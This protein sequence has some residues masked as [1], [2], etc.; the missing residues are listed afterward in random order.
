M[1]GPKKGKKRETIEALG[2]PC[3]SEM[4]KKRERDL[5]IVGESGRRRNRRS[6]YLRVPVG[7]ERKRR[8]KAP[9]EGGKGGTRACIRPP[10][11]QT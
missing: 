8:K 7:R 3:A 5:M 6:V 1:G 2:E 11:G 4:E 9:S 10:I